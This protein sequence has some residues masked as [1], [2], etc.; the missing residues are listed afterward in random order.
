MKFD[1]PCVVTVDLDIAALQKA[2]EEEFVRSPFVEEK[3]ASKNFNE[4]NDARKA[5]RLERVRK[6]RE[7]ILRYLQ[8][9]PARIGV[10]Q[11][12]F[13]Q[14][15]KRAVREALFALRDEKLVDLSPYGVFSVLPVAIESHPDIIR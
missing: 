5:A 9:S 8:N 3:L 12:A 11:T 10:L 2:F 6:A 14:Y 7:A 15:G 13:P 1:L 4:V